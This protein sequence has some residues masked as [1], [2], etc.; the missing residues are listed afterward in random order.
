MDIEQRAFDDDFFV[1]RQ[2]IKE[3]ERR[4]AAL[5]SQSFDD[6]DTLVGKFKLL[7]GFE[8]LLDRP[9]I[10]DELERRQLILLELAKNDFKKVNQI[11]QEGRELINKNA[12]NS[13]LSHNM[14][15]IAGALT[16]I[17]GLKGRLEEPM[18]RL[19]SFP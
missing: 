10:Q 19:M 4:L 7:E 16:W 6:C 18:E 2:T 13:P 3:L 15:P 5:L 11:F 14:P 9:S 17:N 8:G 1:F 12:G